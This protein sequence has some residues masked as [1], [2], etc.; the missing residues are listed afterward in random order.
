MSS[1]RSVL[2][3]GCSSGIGFTAAQHLAGR[4]WRVFATCRKPQDVERLAGMG[5]ESFQLD[6]DDSASI[7]Q[8]VEEALARTGGRLDALVNNGAW[9]QTG[10]V[11]DLSRAVLRA[12]F[13]TN[14]FGWVELTNR[15]I[16]A[17]RRQGHGRIVM[18]SSVLGL[19]TLPY[20]GAYVASKFALEG[21]S[22][23]LR[24]ELKPAGIHVSLVEPGP[25]ATRFREN[26]LQH[27]R[28]NI[29][30][31]ASAHRAAYR[32][33]LARLEK[34]G[35]AAPFTLPPAAVADRIVHALENPRPKARYYVTV[36]THLIA[37]ARR[38]LTTRGMDRLL[39]LISGGGSR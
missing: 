11:E 8:A 25:I 32:A 34:E 33:Q 12:Q 18:V 7:A 29:D 27:F 20:R 24:L 21:I 16:P 19:A 13:E 30:I 26:A 22:D 37:Y 5:L 15:V 10:A 28:R 9:G 2:I 36:P 31:E 3:T 23:T 38:L 14:V 1:A 6:L 39:E 4:G 35:S 17:M